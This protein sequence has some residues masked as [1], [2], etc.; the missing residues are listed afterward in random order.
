MSLYDR[1]YW[2]KPI[3]QVAIT[4]WFMKTDTDHLWRDLAGYILSRACRLRSSAYL[5]GLLLVTQPAPIFSL[6]CI[7]PKLTHE[8]TVVALFGCHSLVVIHTHFTPTYPQKHKQAH[9]HTLPN[10]HHTDILLASKI[11]EILPVLWAVLRFYN[12]SVLIVTTVLV[13]IMTTT[14]HCAASWRLVSPTC[15]GSC[16]FSAWTAFPELGSRR[17]P[18]CGSR[19]PGCG[20]RRPR[21]AWG[22]QTSQKMDSW[23]PV[24]VH[25]PPLLL[26]ANGKVKNRCISVYKTHSLYITKHTS[27]PV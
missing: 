6:Q 27:G 11:T 7:A 10:T 17:A 25:D 15:G 26:P 1:D 16:D 24:P 8:M 21:N 20:T 2:F 18:S 12:F 23:T 9:M 4:A 22:R 3:K 5:G 13:Q 19:G 14:I